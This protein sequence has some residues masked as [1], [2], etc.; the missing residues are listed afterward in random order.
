MDSKML[1]GQLT[2][3]KV[4]AVSMILSFMKWLG[5]LYTTPLWITTEQSVREETVYKTSIQAEPT[6]MADSGSQDSSHHDVLI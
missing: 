5:L 6:H 2:L 4:M 1:S 3:M